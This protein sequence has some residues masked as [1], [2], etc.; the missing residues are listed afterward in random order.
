MG[1]VLLNG[2]RLGAGSLVAAGAVLLEGTEVPPGS[3][4]A[5]VPAKVRRP[6]TTEES[7]GILEA[8]QRYVGNARRHRAA[9]AAGGEGGDDGTAVRGV[10]DRA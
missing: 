10:V 8:A 2:V 7:A 1:S 9:V 6:L 3:L 4:V 5:G